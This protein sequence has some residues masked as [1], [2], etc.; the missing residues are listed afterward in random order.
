MDWNKVFFKT[1]YEKR[2]IAHLLV[3]F[4]RI[5]I[6]HIAVFWF[7]TAFNS[8][9]VYAPK[10]LQRPSAPM[11]WSATALGGAVATTIMILAT[12]AEFAYIPTS[13]NNASH[14]TR[15]LLFLLVVLALTGGPTV[16]IAKVDTTTSTSMMAAS[17]PSRW[18]RGRRLWVLVG[19]VIGGRWHL[20]AKPGMGRRKVEENVNPTPNRRRAGHNF[21][22]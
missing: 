22:G 15:R 18:S 17:R 21:P 6:I 20:S 16:Y 3:N 13:W 10:L 1:Y 19:Q 12:L 5:W 7:Y 8:P 9:K 4:N 14:L 11:T 2:S